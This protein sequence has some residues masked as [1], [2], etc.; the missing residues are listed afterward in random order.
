MNYSTVL[1]LH[2]AHIMTRS[3]HMSP[4][5][6]FVTRIKVFDRQKFPMGQRSN[7]SGAF[8]IFSF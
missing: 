2:V 3:S 1:V 8:L 4:V 5:E 6:A 7:C